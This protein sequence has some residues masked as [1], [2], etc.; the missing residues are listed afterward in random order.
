MFS[1][2]L[3]LDDSNKKIM[4][5][6]SFPPPHTH[7]HTHTYSPK[8]STQISVFYKAEISSGKSTERAPRGLDQER[9]G[10]QCKNHN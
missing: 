1:H 10:R 4:C 2:V 7:T 8:R 3:P 5:L 9:R 6:C